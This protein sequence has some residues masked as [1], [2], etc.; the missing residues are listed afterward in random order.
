MGKC[1]MQEKNIKIGLVG[2]GT[3]GAGVAKIIL[4]NANAIAA[5]TGLRLELACV[6]DDAAMV[7]TEVVRGADLLLSTFRQLL[8]Y[9]A[10]GLAAPAFYHCPLLTDEHGVRLAKRHEALSLRSLRD[11]GRSPEN[12]RAGWR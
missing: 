2:F 4:E 5:K 9:R 11:Q 12:I 1:N 7:I 3:V 8:L 6:V 10:L